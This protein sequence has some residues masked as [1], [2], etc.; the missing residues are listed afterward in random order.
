MGIVILDGIPHE[1]PGVEVKQDP[2]PAG[3]TMSSPRRGKSGYKWIVLHHDAA[4]SAAGCKATLV[5][6]TK[7]GRPVSTH[8]CI[9]NDS[10]IYQYLDPLRFRS[11]ATGGPYGDFNAGG[12][13]IDFSNACE[14]K[15]ASRYKPPRVIETQVI[16]GSP[17][18]W[19]GLYF[20]QVV[21]CAA[22]V[23]LLCQVT[24][25]PATVPLQDGVPLLHL[26]PRPILPGVI[27]HLHC[28]TDKAGQPCKFDPFGL[29][30]ATFQRMIS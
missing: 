30:W 10:T 2:F 28:A 23:K 27:G 12:I 3:V 24:G 29:D 16:H 22:L 5:D 11:W 1:L 14:L 7:K 9:D 18:R 21:A 15:F 8:F 20:Q 13:A 6:S 25:I 4:L 26:L 17:V 19:L